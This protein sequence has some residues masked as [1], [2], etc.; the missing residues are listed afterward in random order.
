M[1]LN[2]NFSITNQIA[3]ALTKIERARGFLEAARLSEEWIAKMQAKILILEAHYTTH[4]EG[5][6][7]TMDQ[8]EKLL[9]GQKVLEADPEDIKELLNYKLAF[10]LVADYIGNG[11]PITEGLIREIHKKLVHGVRGNSAAPGEYRKTQNYVVNS[12]TKEVIYTPPPPYEVP[13][14]MVE[15]VN[16][17][18]NKSGMNP[19][20]VAGI[21]QFQLVHIH[22][23]L[24]GNGRTARLLS[25]LCLYKTGYDFKRLFT[26][27]EYYDRD[28]ANYYKAIRSVRGNKMDMTKWLEYF[29]HGLATQMQEMQ[30]SGHQIMKLDVLALEHGLSKRE[31]IALEKALDPEGLSIKEYQELCPN[32]SKRTL[33]RELKNLV[34]IGL[35]RVKGATNDRCYFANL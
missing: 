2:P 5:T 30:N 31:K 11:E 12:K 34:S 9:T 29:V 14:M 4:I 1:S 24:D 25:T 28:R 17:L 27:S 20:L 32:T 6:H 7:L 8:S 13:L 21:A 35:L 26:I 22:P 10:E 33:Q 23:F 19:I 16:W 18:K 15:L 3:S